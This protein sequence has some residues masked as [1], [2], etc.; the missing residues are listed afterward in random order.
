VVSQI[1][2]TDLTYAA[3]YIQSRNFRA[4]E[5]YLLITAAYLVMAIVLRFVLNA[6][7]KRL[8]ARN[9]RGAR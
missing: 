1:S 3:S 9:L 4:F 8:F 5:T 2:V 6:V 7:G